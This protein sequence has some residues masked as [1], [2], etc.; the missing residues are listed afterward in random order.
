MGLL[1]RMKHTVTLAAYAHASR[2]RPAKLG[3]VVE[4]NRLR[5]TGRRAQ[6][7]ER[8]QAGRRSIHLDRNSFAGVVVDDVERAEGAAVGERVERKVH[9]PPFAAPRRCPVTGRAR[10]A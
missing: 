6:R 4:H 3:S 9:R 8:A 7:L 5:Q 1:G 10:R 2:V